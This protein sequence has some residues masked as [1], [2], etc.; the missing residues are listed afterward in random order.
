MMFSNFVT[1]T[2]VVKLSKIIAYKLEQINFSD[3]LLE[4]VYIRNDFESVQS[5]F[6]FVNDKSKITDYIYRLFWGSKSFNSWMK[7]LVKFS[8]RYSEVNIILCIDQ[9]ILSACNKNNIAILRYLITKGKKEK[10]HINFSIFKNAFLIASENGHLNIVKYLIKICPKL[11]HNREPLIVAVS[12]SHLH[13]LIYLVG[14]GANIHARDD[15]AIKIAIQN[16]DLKIIRYLIAVGAIVPQQL[17]LTSIHYLEI[18][19]C[20][21]QIELIKLEKESS[22][23]CS[24]TL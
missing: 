5:I 12:K 3:D 7:I 15:L 16:D 10:K 8:I 18:L 23:K 21:N 20:L 6:E 14:K 4:L 22:Y 11:V 2:E 13:I 1:F 19:E 24:V 17:I 9:F